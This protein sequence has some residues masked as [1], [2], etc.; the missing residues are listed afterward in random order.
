MFPERQGSARAACWVIFIEDLSALVG[1]SFEKGDDLTTWEHLVLQDKRA[2]DEDEVEEEH[3]EGEAHVHAPVKN[4]DGDDHEEQHHEED[5]DGAGHA[6]A[7]DVDWPEDHAGE[8]PRQRKPVKGATA[9]NSGRVCREQGISTLLSV[10]VALLHHPRFHLIFMQA[11]RRNCAIIDKM[12]RKQASR[13]INCITTVLSWE[14][15]GQT[16]TTQGQRLQGKGLC[17]CLSCPV[18]RLKAVAGKRSAVIL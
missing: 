3:D 18:L 6:S 1:L 10:L 8:E 14:Q 12:S 5:E 9:W 7:A 15:I 11:T 17:P 13:W 16:R 4:G 2:G